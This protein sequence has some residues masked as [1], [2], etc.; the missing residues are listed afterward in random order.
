MRCFGPSL[1]SALALGAETGLLLR[2]ARP[3]VGEQKGG[4]VTG[5]GI[6]V[7]LCQNL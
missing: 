5:M 3:A 6:P 7:S 2:L 4:K 1:Y